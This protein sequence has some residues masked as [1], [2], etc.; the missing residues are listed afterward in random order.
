MI[1]ASEISQGQIIVVASAMT[2]L[3]YSPRPR[4]RSAELKLCAERT[5]PFGL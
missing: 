3:R 2:R 1:K 5:K 4:P